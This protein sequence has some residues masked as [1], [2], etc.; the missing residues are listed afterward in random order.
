MKS[1]NTQFSLS[2]E[3]TRTLL[4]VRFLGDNSGTVTISFLRLFQ[5]SGS[6]VLAENDLAEIFKCHRIDPDMERTFRAAIIRPGHAVWT[7]VQ[8]LFDRMILDNRPGP[9]VA[10]GLRQPDYLP[11]VIECSFLA[12]VHE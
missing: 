2:W 8:Y 9:T 1:P 5:N 6:D 10:R 7:S 12:W 3:L 11:M 4:V